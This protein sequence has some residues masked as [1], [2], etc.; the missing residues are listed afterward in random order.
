MKGKIPILN[1]FYRHHAMVTKIG[2]RSVS[3]LYLVPYIL[4][5]KTS[6]L[7]ALTPCAEMS[8]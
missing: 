7:H 2:K 6:H 5:A 3:Y 4:Q 8:L 1:R